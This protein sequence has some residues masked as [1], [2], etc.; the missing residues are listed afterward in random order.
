MTD[1]LRLSPAAQG[2]EFQGVG[3]RLDLS[4]V[5]LRQRQSPSLCRTLESTERLELALRAVEAEGAGHGTDMGE[6]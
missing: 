2:L 6:G 5:G 3:L 4:R 1:A